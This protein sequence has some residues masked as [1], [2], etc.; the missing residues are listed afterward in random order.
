MLALLLLLL[1]LTPHAPLTPSHSFLFC[2]FTAPHS[3]IF[4]PA[5]SHSSSLLL[6]PNAAPCAS[7]LL[8]NSLL[9]LLSPSHTSS[10]LHTASSRPHNSLL[11]PS[12]QSDSVLHTHQHSPSHPLPSFSFSLTLLH[13]F[14][15][16]TPPPDCSKLLL[17]LYIVPQLPHTSSLSHTPLS[18]R[19]TLSLTPTRHCSTLLLIIPLLCCG[20]RQADQVGV[21]QPL[22]CM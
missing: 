14:A 7:S 6:T 8:L 13:L 22:L 3:S 19:S 17:P 5:P 2:S 21:S 11:L 9:L 16:L 18:H 15:L 12:P 20:P 1:L 10:L 4:P